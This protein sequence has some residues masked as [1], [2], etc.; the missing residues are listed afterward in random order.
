[1]LECK[2]GTIINEAEVK[3]SQNSPSILQC[4]NFQKRNEFTMQL[5]LVLQYGQT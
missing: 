2:A 4:T 3:L 5:K 1:M